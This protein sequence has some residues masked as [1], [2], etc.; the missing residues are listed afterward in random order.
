MSDYGDEVRLFLVLENHCGLL[1]LYSYPTYPPSNLKLDINELLQ[2]RTTILLPSRQHL[3]KPNSVVS[4]SR[5]PCKL[6]R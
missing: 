4:R 2:Y 6:T 1:N 3:P 5:V